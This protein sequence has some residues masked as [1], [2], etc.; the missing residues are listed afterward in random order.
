LAGL[1]RVLEELS[2]QERFIELYAGDGPGVV[3]F[4]LPDKFVLAARKLGIWLE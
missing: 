1:N 3:A 2:V 4:A